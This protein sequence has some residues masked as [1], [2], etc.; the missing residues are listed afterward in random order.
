MVPSPAQMHM[1]CAARQAAQTGFLQATL[2]GSAVAQSLAVPTL[3]VR[4]SD[5][6]VLSFT[7]KTR[8]ATFARF[9]VARVSVLVMAASGPPYACL[10]GCCVQCGSPAWQP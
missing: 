10:P 9:P 8:P 1:S 6:A 7:V 4:D 5:Q 3:C 2:C